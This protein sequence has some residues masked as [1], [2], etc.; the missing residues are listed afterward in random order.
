MTE[1]RHYK[2]PGGQLL[3][4]DWPPH[5]TVHAQITRGELRR[6]DVDG[7]PYVEP[8]EDGEPPVVV[9]LTPPAATAKKDDWVGYV[10]R[11]TEA[12]AEPVTVDQAQAMT[13]KD[14]QERYGQ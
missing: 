11:L 2:G 10:V 5:E 6:C 14:M 7:D 1:T 13:V 8:V 3:H 9:A 4:L 12:T